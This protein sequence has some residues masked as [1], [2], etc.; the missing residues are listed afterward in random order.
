VLPLLHIGTG[1]V[2]PGWLNWAIETD[3]VIITVLLLYGYAYAA[4][5][6]RWRL[7]DAGRVKGSQVA[8]FLLGVGAL[9]FATGGPLHDLAD[10]YLVSAHMLQHVMLMIVVP[11]LFIAGVP[12][13]LWQ[14]FLRQPGVMPVA[15]V[16]THPL[17]ALGAFN[18]VFL[19]THLPPVVE[20]QL[21]SGLFHLLVHALQVAVGIVMWWLVVSPL[22]E[23]PPLSYPYQMGYL[24]VQSLLP[25]VF[26]GVFTFSTGAIYPFY[27]QQPRLWGISIVEDQQ[28][29]AAIMKIL[30]SIIIWS[31]IGVA[32]FKWFAKEEAEARGPRWSEVEEE[33]Q[34]LGLTSRR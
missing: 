23:L 11:P 25:A 6:L 29:A 22:S 12:S 4:T 28:A 21:S 15:R 13:W 19:L 33:L 30:G 9:Y 26:A 17:V 10:R 18:A 31:F 16:V 2:G 7:P 1:G 32:F 20:L 24:F 34:E 14:T 8:Y 27:D 3:V 5:R